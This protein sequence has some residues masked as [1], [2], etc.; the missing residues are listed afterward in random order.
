MSDE[1]VE[2]SLASNHLLLMVDYC[3]KMINLARSTGLPVEST[4][5]KL[6]ISGM[7]KGFK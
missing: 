2:S 3:E 6:I 1:E 4:A 5:E 7:L